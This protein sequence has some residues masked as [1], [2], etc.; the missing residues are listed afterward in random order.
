[1]RALHGT[2]FAKGDTVAAV[3][4]KLTKRADDPLTDEEVLAALGWLLRFETKDPGMRLLAVNRRAMTSV[5]MF[6][7]DLGGPGW[8]P[9]VWPEEDLRGRKFLPGV[10]VNGIGTVTAIQ[11]PEN[12]LSGEISRELVKG[13]PGLVELDLSRNRGLGGTLPSSVSGLPQCTR[14]DLSECSFEGPL[15]PQLSLL[16]SLRHLLLQGN[17]FSGALLPRL[18]DLTKLETMDL[19]GNK[20]GF[21]NK[22]GSLFASAWCA[23]AASYF[24][25]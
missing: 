19:T 3:V 11:L 20:C 9:R 10:E 2:E 24:A 15:P 1:M 16:R 13:I 17:G 4:A 5:A 8:A 6:Y 23:A 22:C 7:R 18:V 21:G 25:R 12:G 14:L